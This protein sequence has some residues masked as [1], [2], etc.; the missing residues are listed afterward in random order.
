M[1]PRAHSRVFIGA[2]MAVCAV[3]GLALG[4][5]VLAALERS[6]ALRI[7]SEEDAGQVAQ[8]DGRILVYTKSDRARSCKLATTHWLFTMVK[9]G[10]RGDLVRAYVPIAEDGPVPVTALG[11]TGYI[12]SVPLPPGL[13]P[14][15]WYWIEAR[16]ETCGILGAIWPIYSESAPL[17]LNIERNRAI[18]DTP[19]T[20]LRNGE[21]TTRSR[22]PLA[23][24][25]VSK[26]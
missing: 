24:D 7:L 19:V 6:P 17:L 11:V 14:A 16:A 8:N 22:S 26:P 12:L 3:I 20:A 13:W 15:Q 2:V 25:T 5:V 9:N 21:T 23:G 18:A 10:D 1:T 4:S